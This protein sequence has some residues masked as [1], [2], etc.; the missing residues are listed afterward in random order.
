MLRD[1]TLTLSGSA[2]RLSAVLPNLED[3]NDKFLQTLSLQPAGANANPV[4]VGASAVSATEYGVRLEAGTAGVPPAP[5]LASDAFKATG[6]KL[7][8]VYVIG[9]NTQVLHILIVTH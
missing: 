1:Y 3:V 6:L 2:Q 8:D 9:T 7:S 5:W 4:Y